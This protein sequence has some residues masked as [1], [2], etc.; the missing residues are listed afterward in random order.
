MATSFS[1]RILGPT[2]LK[3]KLRQIAPETNPEI[4]RRALRRSAEL[5][6]RLARTRYLSGPRP[7]RLAEITGELQASIGIDD[8]DLP[9][10]IVVGTPLY[11]AMLHEFGP[12]SWDARPFLGPALEDAKPEIERFFSDSLEQSIDS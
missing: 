4:A 6:Q 2:Q 5:V 9:G 12:G 7:R 3:K 10:R 8:S 1:V 11:W